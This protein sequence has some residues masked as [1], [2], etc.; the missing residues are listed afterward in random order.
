MSNLFNPS[1]SS[2]APVRDETDIFGGGNTNPFSDIAA[3]N[4]I[5]DL[6]E[7]GAG[8]PAWRQ[9]WE[10]WGEYDLG[11]QVARPTYT[12]AQDLD[13]MSIAQ[14]LGL[15]G[16]W[17]Q[18]SLPGA[19]P[20]DRLL[21]EGMTNVVQEVQADESISP[22]ERIARTQRT[23]L[24]TQMLRKLPNFSKMGKLGGGFRL[25]MEAALKTSFYD[26]SPN[27]Y[28]G[29]VRG[30]P[31]WEDIIDNPFIPDED[32]EI[33]FDIGDE[34]DKWLDE[35]P[36]PEDPE[37]PTDPED[38]TEPPPY[39]CPP[40]PSTDCYAPDNKPLIEE[41]K[42]ILEGLNLEAADLSELLEKIEE[43][44][45]RI[46]DVEDVVN[47]SHT[48]LKDLLESVQETLDE[49]FPAILEKAEEIA[50]SLSEFID[51]MTLKVK[52]IKDVTDD[53][54][55]YLDEQIDIVLNASACGSGEENQDFRVSDSRI[56]AIAKSI[57]LLAEVLDFHGQKICH[58]EATAAVPEW[59]STRVGADRTLAVVVFQPKDSRGNWL[60]STY[61]MS[62]PWARDSQ[63]VGALP[64]YWKGP[65]YGH[66]ILADNSKLVVN[67]RSPQEAE[68]MIGRLKSLISASRLNG[69]VE[70]YGKNKGTEIKTQRVHP[71][72]MYYFSTGQ[73][74][75]KPDWV[76]EFN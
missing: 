50:S 72:Y 7:E 10:R 56:V 74:T 11:T 14:S 13:I 35:N 60:K 21:H 28:N 58:I 70:R 62:I 46:D 4:N 49:W 30:L 45:D 41:I 64:S 18:M 48:T 37:E 69:S 68:R 33:I 59:W 73:R 24:V 47:D 66:L 8:G 6:W 36:L 57:P 1:S 23:V 27:F 12:P 9:E 43:V 19:P 63:P 71:R 53:I 15:G 29:P 52:E 2:F 51:N 54:F 16:V 75:T 67:A 32:K 38:P 61:P 25:L 44:S 40:C 76:K 34:I 5:V 65:H 39:S 20:E 42:T 26:D 31:E 3:D 22:A 17:A 55:N